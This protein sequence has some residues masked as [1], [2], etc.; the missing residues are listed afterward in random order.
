MGGRGAAQEA[1]NEYANAA[2]EIEVDTTSVDFGQ[3]EP[4][5][6]IFDKKVDAKS[7]APAPAAAEEPQS[8]AV[9]SESAEALGSQE[10]EADRA[11]KELFPEDVETEAA[12]DV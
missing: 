10:D 3:A 2:E 12:S 9:P 8:D 4:G 11:R 5:R 7:Q 1:M 6:D